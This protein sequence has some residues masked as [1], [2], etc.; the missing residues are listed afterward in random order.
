M[1][2]S[3][4][5]DVYH[6]L[7]GHLKEEYLVPGVE[8]IF[9]PGSEYYENYAAMLDA[10]ERLCNRLGR[11]VWDD[12]DVEII[13]SALLDNEEI[14]ALKMFEYGQNKYRTGG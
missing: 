3:N 2:P 6:T 8:N 14:I 13:I 10:Y 5:E 7:L 4:A 9:V 12:E 11:A 1:K